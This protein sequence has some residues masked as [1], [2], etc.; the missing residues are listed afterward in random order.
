MNHPAYVQHGTL[1]LSILNAAGLHVCRALGISSGA[2]AGVVVAAVIVGVACLVV[3]GG[4]D[5][6]YLFRV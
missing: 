1:P 5:L 3:A 6:D 2:I 4:A